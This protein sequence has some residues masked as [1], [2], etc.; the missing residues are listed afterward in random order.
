[1]QAIPRSALS[2]CCFV[3][4]CS[5]TC[6]RAEVFKALWTEPVYR[7]ATFSPDESV[8]AGTYNEGMVEF[9][10]V[11]NGASL[12]S[13][14][15]HSA[16]IWDLQFSA[17]GQYLATSSNDKSVKLF[18]YPEHSLVFSFTTPQSAAPIAIS[19]DA[20][21][22]AFADST[23]IALHRI[24][25]GEHIRTWQASREPS[26]LGG[27]NALRFTPDGTRLVSGSGARGIGVGLN[28]WDVATGSLVWS[29]RTAHSYGID[30]ISISR[31]G[32]LVTTGGRYLGFPSPLE[33]WD[34]NNGALR[35][36]VSGSAFC[37]DF[38]PQG[39][40]LI[41]VHTNL[42]LYSLPPMLLAQQPEPPGF[43]AGRVVEFSKSGKYFLV[44]GSG[45]YLYETPAVFT[46]VEA[47]GQLLRLRW[48]AP[49]G[50]RVE[51]STNLASG[52]TEWTGN[53]PNQLAVPKGSGNQFFRV[54]R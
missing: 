50:A 15:A 43:H 34:L 24:P 11:T 19:P 49:E 4:I 12:D 31:D 39:S 5:V 46:H 54:R 1:M 9:L 23:N 48:I 36:A 32:K 27:L 22:F 40:A 16:I 2:V 7:V 42:S 41:T 51:S 38:H 21:M 33:I 37:S 52:W 44:A 14:T 29:N 35:H 20:S 47:L 3:L 25:S 13:F 30:N 8:I 17:D 6:S 28:V 10:N 26:I 53:Q 45:L 18:R